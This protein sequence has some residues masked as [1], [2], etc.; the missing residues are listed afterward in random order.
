MKTVQRKTTGNEH[1]LKL[2]ITWA[3]NICRYILPLGTTLIDAV[4]AMMNSYSQNSTFG[5]NVGLNIPNS[6]YIF[7]GV[8]HLF[9]INLTLRYDDFVFIQRTCY[10]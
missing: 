2:T 8:L 7:T 4:S 9:G 6:V 1:M 3:S 5:G 10:V